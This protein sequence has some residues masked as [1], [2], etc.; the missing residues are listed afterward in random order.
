MSPELLGVVIG[1]LIGSLSSFIGIFINHWLEL[2]RDK[3]H[4]KLEAEREFRKKL[5]D[6]ISPTIY[7]KGMEKLY[8][9][10]DEGKIPRSYA[11]DPK[12]FETIIEELEDVDDSDHP[13]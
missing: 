11:M 2:K 1:G 13:F 7:D 8:S 6:G 9:M 5:T 3:Y 10:I 12:F 4:M